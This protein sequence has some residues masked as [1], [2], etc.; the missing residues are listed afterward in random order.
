[1]I[2]LFQLLILKLFRFKILLSVFFIFLSAPLK[3]EN[4]TY[5][6][7]KNNISSNSKSN[8]FSLPYKILVEVNKNK[9]FQINNLKIL[10]STNLINKKFKKRYSGKVKVFYKDKICVF[11]A[12]IR[13]HGDFK[14]HIKLVKGNV[15]QSL[16]I[17]LKDG[18]ING[19]TK[20][21]LFLP[22]TR[23]NPEEEIVITE[24]F[25]SLNILAPRTFFINV[26]NQS[27]NYLALFQEKT[28]K[29][30]LEFNNRKESV[31]L[32][33]DERFIF[34]VD[35]NNFGWESKLISLARIS[36]DNLFDKS[37]IYK[38]ILLNSLS[39]LNKFYLSSKNYYQHYGN[40]DYDPSKINEHYLDKSSFL[41]QK[42]KFSI[43]NSLIFA[44]NAQ[45][46][47][48]PHNR[49]FYWNK[50]YQTFEPIYYDGNINI[51]KELDINSFPKKEL[52]FD[53]IKKTLDLLNTLDNKSLTKK[54]AKNF[55]VVEVDINQINLKIDKIKSNLSNILYSDIS[56]T[57]FETI[58][59]LDYYI[60]NFQNYLE[61][62]NKN[63][64]VPVFTDRELN[65]FYTCSYDF[66]NLIKL[67]ENEFKLLINGNLKKNDIFYQFVGIKEIKDKKIIKQEV[68][69]ISNH[70]IIDYQNSKIIYDKKQ[71]LIK[72]LQPNLIEIK[73]LIPNSRI[74]L[75]GGSLENLKILAN[76]IPQPKNSNEKSFGTKGLTGCLNL[77]D[78]K[79]KNIDIEITNGN[80][81]DGLNIIRSTG[82]INKLIAVDSSNDALDIDFSD[83]KISKIDV[84]SA[85]NDCVDL[86]FGKYEIEEININDCGDKAISVGEKSKLLINKLNVLNSKIG[87]A[88]KDSSKTK[89]ENGYIKHLD[90]CLSAYNKKQEFIGGFIEINNFDCLNSTNKIFVDDMSSINLNS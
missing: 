49:K 20:F 88:S 85:G 79:F 56:K 15:N 62:I 29:E 82:S 16:D 37:N 52:F 87:I 2:K 35:D 66:C 61:R 44:T 76:F 17:H 4:N 59:E 65:N 6:C 34:D 67:D 1:M 19:I 13:I 74:M 7:F 83:L 25:R 77:I 84:T 12:N 11:K 58:N 42:V 48:A 14:D 54:I 33:G 75:V 23:N 70:E 22:E 41:S 73:Q 60:N 46:A 51:N 24:I 53:N 90:T 39:N 45:H 57:K 55:N 21:K 30:F 80:C 50:E 86:S 63:K 64:I 78:M 32:E 18:N 81:E 47:L 68:Q 31:I 89:L 26:D 3:A 40:Y 43:F 38:E 72:E 69:L 8:E 27:N 36:N 5:P 28:E 9:K 10:K 71:Y